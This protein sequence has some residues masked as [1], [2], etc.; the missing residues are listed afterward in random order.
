M[1]KASTVLWDGKDVATF[2][3]RVK[4]ARFLYRYE[5]FYPPILSIGYSVHRSEGD[6]LGSSPGPILV[7]PDTLKMVPK[8]LL[9]CSALEIR[10]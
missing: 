7:I 2:S 1:G 5:D 6:D 8:L 4:T 10:R 3:G 9:L